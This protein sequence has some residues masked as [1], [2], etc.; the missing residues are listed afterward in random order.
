[1]H[2]RYSVNFQKARKSI[3]LTI[4]ALQLEDSATYLCA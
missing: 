3:D 1:K 2:D 4:S